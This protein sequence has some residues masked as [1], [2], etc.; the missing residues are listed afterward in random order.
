MSLYLDFY[1][2]IPHTETGEPTRREFLGL[3]IAETP[4]TTMDKAH[5]KETLSIGESILQKQ[6]NFLNRINKRVKRIGVSDWT[7][8]TFKHAT[9]LVAKVLASCLTLSIDT[10]SKYQNLHRRNQLCLYLA[11]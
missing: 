2:P 10:A 7:I 1:P 9:N 5:K 8:Q 4:K 3:Y 11:T 6:E